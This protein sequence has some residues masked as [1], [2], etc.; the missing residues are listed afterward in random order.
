MLETWSASLAAQSR[1]AASGGEEGIWMDLHIGS[2][3]LGPLYL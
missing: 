3:F 1:V 2:S